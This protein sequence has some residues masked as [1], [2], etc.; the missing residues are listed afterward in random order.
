MRFLFLGLGCGLFYLGRFGGFF[1]LFAGL[2]EISRDQ[3][4]RQNDAILP[5][6]WALA[7][8]HI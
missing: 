2:P 3:A 5:V 4:R 6:T 1:S 7:A 8:T